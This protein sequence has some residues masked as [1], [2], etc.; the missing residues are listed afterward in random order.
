MIRNGSK[1]KKFMSFHEEQII[2]HFSSFDK[3][4]LRS[5]KSTYLPSLVFRHFALEIW[6]QWLNNSVRL[7][8]DVKIHKCVFKMR[9]KNQDLFSFDF[10]NAKTAVVCFVSVGAANSKYW[11][12]TNTSLKPAKR[13]FKE[14]FKGE[15]F[16]ICANYLRFSLKNCTLLR[17]VLFKVQLFWKSTIF[18]NLYL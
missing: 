8:I 5:K 16:C 15:D 13:Q 18:C 6:S 9:L 4:S 12:I 2:R 10:Q 3:V 11:F 14:N 17:N 1:K 7:T